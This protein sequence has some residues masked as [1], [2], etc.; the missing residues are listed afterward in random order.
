M[1]KALAVLLLCLTAGSATAETVTKERVDRA[2]EA[3]IR[4]LRSRQM[5]NGGWRFRNNAGY[6]VGATGL[7]VAALATAGVKE[8]DP[9][10][11]AGVKF[12][13]ANNPPGRKTYQYSIK[14]I[15]LAAVNPK[16]YYDQIVMATQWLENAQ[17]SNG[18]WGYEMPCF[19]CPGE[20]DNSNT[21]FAV[22]GLHTASQAGVKISRSVL[23]RTEKM[24][25][26][27]QKGD[28]GWSYRTA[29]D[30][31]V[32][33][34][35]AA[36]A[37]LY[38]AGN[39]LF[40]PTDVCGEYTTNRP[41]ARGMSWLA[42]N[43]RKWYDP[44]PHLYYTLYAIERAGV[45]SSQ[46]TI[47]KTDWF[48]EG[49]QFLL[50]KQRSDGSWAKNPVDTSFAL[51]FLVKGKA[52][53][54][55]SKL[56][57]RGKWNNTI[58]DVQNLA[59]FYGA[60][61]G[62]NVGW[63]AV[64]VDAPLEEML[65]APVLFLNG[66]TEVNF[67]KDEL[68]KLR[69]YVR[70]GGTIW[71]ETCCG[72]EA[73]DRSFRKVASKLFPE[74]RLQ[75]L[76]TDHPIYHSFYDVEEPPFVYAINVGCRIGLIYHKRNLSVTWERKD[77][78]STAYKMGMNILRFVLSDRRLV[79]RLAEIKPVRDLSPPEILPGALTLAQVR[80]PAWW[81]PFPHALDTLAGYLRL[82][83]NMNISTRKAVVEAGSDQIFAYPI[84]YVTGQRE[85]VFTKD[86]IEHLRT[87]LS[88]GG[89]LF[90]DATC[91][92]REYDISFRMFAKALYPDK[93][94]ERIPLGDPIF[95]SA[96][97]IKTVK[98]KEAV[99]RKEPGKKEPFLEGIRLGSRWAVVYSKY[100]LSAAWENQVVPGSMGVERE[101]AF[102]LGANIIVYACAN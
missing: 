23:S 46:K 61:T 84:L 83:L 98:Y 9:T 57:W 72:V 44:Q 70:N 74:R 94:L 99:L 77:Y 15:A 81:E 17:L 30:S 43:H 29:G 56:R 87:Y 49:A 34:T 88:R 14:I 79:D 54:L 52:P 96:Y 67:T 53:L 22:L 76:S 7:A 40:V 5:R 51:L 85:V 89:F 26:K 39:E 73:F 11:A 69:D 37:T 71:A 35:A 21:Q 68:R 16:K 31:R 50:R 78:E 1:K 18:R 55:I 91:G 65:K 28:G 8:D 2:I 48:M 86:D 101:D 80:H 45:L 36:I 82:S 90:S 60:C 100:N 41:L 93:K 13:L 10:L 12:L 58:H 20:G 63:Q 27:T 95:K 25:L 32:S 64:C 66:N 62:E 75:L 19:G 6:D 102:R 97:N 42:R 92:R 59:R 38:I 47:G 3:G 4:Y 33:M 24:L